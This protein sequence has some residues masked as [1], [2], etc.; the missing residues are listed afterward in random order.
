MR[1]ETTGRKTTAATPDAPAAVYTI[2]EFCSA[3]R[4]SPAMFYKMKNAGIG[5]RELR[6]G[7]RRLIT[8]EAAADWRRARETATDQ[9]A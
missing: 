4:I 1:P 6:V 9:V 3:H 5:P 2:P 8:F 7:S